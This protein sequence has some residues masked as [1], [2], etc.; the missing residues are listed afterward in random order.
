[1]KSGF[2]DINS[3]HLWLSD[4]VQI[5][6]LVTPFSSKYLPFTALASK[7]TKHF[8]NSAD[9]AQTRRISKYKQKPQHSILLQKLPT[10]SGATT[11]LF[12]ANYGEISEALKIWDQL[13]NSSFVPNLDIASSLIKAYAK[14]GYF[15]GVVGVLNWLKSKEF[16][17]LP[18]VYAVAVHCFGMKGE[19]GLMEATLK[20]MVSFQFPVDSVTGNAYLVYYSR[21]GS[22]KEMEVAYERIKRSRI[23]IEEP[24]VRSISSAYMKRKKFHGLGEFLRDV[25]LDRRN[26]GNLLWNLLLL[27][28]AVNFKMKSLQRNFLAMVESGFQPDLT[29]FNIR[30]MAFSRMNLFWDLHLSLEHMNHVNVAPDLVTYGCVVDAYL[31]KKIGRNLDFALNR[32][33]NKDD[34]PFVLTEDYVCEVLGKGDFHM[35]SEAFME[36]S[37]NKSWTCRKLVGIYLKKQSRSRQILWNY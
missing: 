6:H 26:F 25:G 2:L 27:S 20:E 29:T 9:Y 32:M 7:Q 13:T 33:I 5:K 4:A 8:E 22:L 1:M 31:E 21:Y 10:D 30:A 15:D 23:L 18:Q 24:A 35:S 12:H 28:Y 36:F 16:S 3:S 37:K 11:M 14:R 17:W 19:L 34:P